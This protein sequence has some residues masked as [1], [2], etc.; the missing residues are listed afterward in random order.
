MV[1]LWFTVLSPRL[2]LPKA[3][4]HCTRAQLIRIKAYYRRLIIVLKSPEEDTPVE[5]PDGKNDLQ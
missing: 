3:A 4:D 2:F 1:S 5:K